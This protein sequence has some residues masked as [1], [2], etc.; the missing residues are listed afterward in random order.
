VAGGAGR[1]VA[2]HHV[3]V[4]MPAGQDE[5]AEGF[6]CGLLGFERVEKPEALRA[7]GGCWFRSGAAECHLGVEDDFRPARKAHPAFLVDDLA[8]IRERLERAGVEVVPDDQVEGHE[9][10]YVRDPFG[11]RLEL[12]APVG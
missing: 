9:R 4:A 7:R 8:A 3:Q 10:F 1:V 12:I 5:V 11:N 6:Y 2:L